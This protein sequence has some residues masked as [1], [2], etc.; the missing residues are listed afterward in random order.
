MVKT[1][2]KQK[3]STGKLNIYSTLLHLSIYHCV[4]L[5]VKLLNGSS[6]I[7]Q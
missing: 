6:I 2:R 1:Q 4:Q 7:A 3:K 5:T